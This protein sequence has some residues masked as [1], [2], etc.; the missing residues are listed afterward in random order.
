MLKLPPGERVVYEFLKL[1]GVWVSYKAI[2]ISQYIKHNVGDK[3]SVRQHLDS[4]INKRHIRWRRR[5]HPLLGRE[6][7]AVE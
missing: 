4:L 6:Y 3:V 1:K 2:D 5:K 7:R